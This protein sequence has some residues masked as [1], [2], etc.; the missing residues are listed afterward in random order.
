MTIWKTAALGAA[1]AA[2]A[3]VGAVLTPTAHGQTRVVRA[4]SP[5]A[6]EII[7]GGS[8]IGVSIRDLE[9]ADGAGRQGRDGRGHR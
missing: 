9:D 5:R 2:A 1:L 3:G 8:R 6:L 7:T 4:Q